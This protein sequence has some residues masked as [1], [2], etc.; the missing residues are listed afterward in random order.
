MGIVYNI[1]SYTGEFRSKGGV[2]TQGE[3]GAAGTVYLNNVQSQPERKLVIYNQG[4]SGVRVRG[5]QD[6]WGD[7]SGSLL[8]FVFFFKNNCHQYN[9]TCLCYPK[10]YEFYI[11]GK[12][13]YLYDQIIYVLYESLLFII[14]PCICLHKSFL[15]K[16]LLQQ[17]KTD[18]FSAF[19]IYCK[20][21]SQNPR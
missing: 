1:T 9:S 16:K 8:F 11:T 13:L 3:N 5:I 19:F 17:T 10:L 15:F 6:V 14:V 7:I 4:G 20:I 18:R 2:G 12:G 21:K